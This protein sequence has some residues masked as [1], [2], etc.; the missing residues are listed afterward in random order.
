MCAET[1]ANGCSGQIW[2]HDHRAELGAKPGLL[3]LNVG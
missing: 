3:R 2:L 1:Q